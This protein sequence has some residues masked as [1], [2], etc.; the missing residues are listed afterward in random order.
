VLLGYYADGMG[1]IAAG[2]VIRE[3]LPECPLPFAE[4]L[5]R[6]H[7]IWVEVR[8]PT[9]LIG[10]QFGNH[11]DRS[12]YAE[13]LRRSIRDIDVVWEIQ[14]DGSL[15]FVVMLPLSGRAAVEG[16]LT[17]I[18]GL[19]HDRFDKTLDAARIVAYV[20]ELEDERPAIT[21]MLLLE[22]CAIRDRA[23]P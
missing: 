10:L 20:A 1:R 19:L 22:H 9:T 7:R 6:L 23:V 17:R 8:V 18:E 5:V 16:Y 11:P 3:L 12:L 4:E 21:L 14:R 2:Q 13:T 15:V